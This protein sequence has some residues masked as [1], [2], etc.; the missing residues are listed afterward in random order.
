MSE[1]RNIIDHYH[2]WK[3][4]AI[5]ADLD[6]RRHNFTVLCSNLY[7][8]FN[9]ATVIR[10]ANAFLAKEVILY[11]SKQYDRR[12]T[13][14]THNYSRFVHCRDEQALE[15]KIIQL[16]NEHEHLRIVGIDNVRN[17]RPI[18]EYCWAPG[19]HVLMVFG[20]EQVG[21]PPELLDRC[22]DLVYITQYGSVRSLNVGCAS[23]IAMYDYC[24]KIEAGVLAP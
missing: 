14:G 7:N 19:E 3:H 17:A 15:K 10:N 16:A 2:Y 23:S 6:K 20:Q 22:D 1:T 13:V 21:I 12:G 4:E 11:G 9:I 5:L 18:E 24:S 8:D